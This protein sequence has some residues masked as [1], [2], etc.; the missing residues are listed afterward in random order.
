MLGQ[1]AR[2][3][4]ADAGLQQ[5]A[6]GLAE[7]GGEPEVAQQVGVGV[8]DRTPGAG[9][10]LGEAAGQQRGGVLDGG[11]LG[12]VD[13]VDRRL[14][15]VDEFVE[16]LLQRGHGVA[17][18][19][20]HRAFRFGDDR[21]LAS[22]A[23]GE[24]V[25]DAG[26]VAQ[27]RRHQQELDAGQFDQRHL[28]GPAPVGFA[29][30][31]ELVHHDHAHVG[32]RALAERDVR[33]HLG[34]AGDDRGA[35]IDRGV[36]GQH[37][38]V[39][40][41]EDRHQFEELLAD[42]GLH[43]GGVER[44]PVGRQRR[45]D[46]RRR[47]QRLPGSGRG[48]QHHMRTGEQLDDRLVLMRV[49]TQPKPL[50]IAGERLIQSVGAGIVGGVDPERT[51]QSGRVHNR[52]SIPLVAATVPGDQRDGSLGHFGDHGGIFRTLFPVSVGTVPGV[53]ENSSLV[54]VGTV[55]GDR[56]NRPWC[57]GEPSLVSGRTVPGQSRPRSRATAT[58]SPRLPT[59]SLDR[60]LETCT[61]AVLVEMNSWR[62]IWPLLRPS[63]SSARISCSRGVRS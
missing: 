12:E 8:V 53:R 28:P 26:H 10:L 20:W 22:G 5:F 15:G 9:G 25:G 30:V 46:R 36:P 44:H 37:A 56:G 11:G 31:V 21:D 52:S 32:V 45:M 50:G 61:L 19:E 39:V 54:S 24:V 49:E 55:P 16:G 7:A 62:P 3:V 35:G 38:D 42:Q 40:G 48:G 41:A 51:Q 1:H 34:G 6:Q 13:D 60:M 29:V 14:V 27:R 23:P 33:Q 17:E 4:D 57:P 43:R 18:A 2:V 63:A 58:A 47:H 59:P